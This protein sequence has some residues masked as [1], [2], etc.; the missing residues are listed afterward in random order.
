MMQYNKNILTVGEHEFIYVSEHGRDIERKQISLNDMRVLM[1]IDFKLK[2]TDKQVF[3]QD[4]HKIKTQSFVGSIQIDQDLI[5]EILPKFIKTDKDLDAKSIQQYR[6]TLMNMIMLSG[7]SKFL[8]SNNVALKTQNGELP[9]FETLIFF[10][11]EALSQELRKG[12][13]REYMK[14]S[15]NLTQM[16]GRLVTHEHLRRNI[17]NHAKLYVEFETYSIDNNLMRIF[18]AAIRL[19]LEQN[20]ISQITKQKLSEALYL[21]NDVTDMQLALKDFDSVT[22]HRMNSRFEEL[23]SQCRFLIMKF[24]PFSITADSKTKFWSILFDMDELFED[25]LA[26]LFARSEISFEDQY[27]FHAYRA[28]YGSRSVGGRPDFVFFQEDTISSVADAKW[29]LFDPARSSSTNMGG[30]DWGNFWQLTSYMYLLSK[31]PIPGYFIVPAKSKEVPREVHYP[32]PREY[33]AD[34]A[35]LTIDFTMPIADILETHRFSW[36]DNNRLRLSSFMTP[37]LWISRLVEEFDKIR[38]T[39][40]IISVEN[41]NFYPYMASLGEKSGCKISVIALLVINSDSD[42]YNETSEYIK[43]TYG[44]KRTMDS[45][46][47]TELAT[48]MINTYSIQDKLLEANQEVVELPDLIKESDRDQITW[49]FFDTTIDNLYTNFAEYIYYSRS[50][51]A[52]NIEKIKNS[53]MKKPNMDVKHFSLYGDKIVVFKF[54][55]RSIIAILENIPT[56]II[57]KAVKKSKTFKMTSGAYSSTSKNRKVWGQAIVDIQAIISA[58]IE[59]KQLKI[60]QKEAK[61]AYEKPISENIVSVIEKP[62]VRV[63]DLPEIKKFKEQID[64]L[65]E[66]LYNQSYPVYTSNTTIEWRSEHAEPEA[67]NIRRSLFYE[68]TLLC[69][70]IRKENHISIELY[71]V[72]PDAYST[73]LENDTT[74]TLDGVN[75]TAQFFSQIEWI[76]TNGKILD[77][78]NRALSN[79]KTASYL[80]AIGQKASYS[81]TA[82]IIKLDKE[83]IKYARMYTSAKAL[84][85]FLKIDVSDSKLHILDQEKIIDRFVAEIARD[86]MAIT[87]NDKRM[88]DLIIEYSEKYPS[89]IKRLLLNQ[90]VLER[91]LDKHIDYMSFTPE[92]ATIVS[93]SIK[94]A[95]QKIHLKGYKA[96]EE[97]ILIPVNGGN[98]AFKTVATQ[99]LAAVAYSDLTDFPPKLINKII[100]T[101][102]R[103]TPS[104]LVPFTFLSNSTIPVETAFNYYFA[105][106]FYNNPADQIQAAIHKA[107]VRLKNE[108]TSMSSFV[109]FMIE[110]T[111]N[112]ESTRIEWDSITQEESDAIVDL[113]DL[114]SDNSKLYFIWRTL[115]THTDN[116]LHLEKMFNGTE[117]LTH[118]QKEIIYIAI[119]LAKM[120]RRAT[121]EDLERYKDLLH[122]IAIAEEALKDEYHPSVVSMLAHNYSIRD[123]T[124]E[125]IFNLYRDSEGIMNLLIKFANIRPGDVSN[126]ILEY[127]TKKAN[128]YYYIEANT[129]TM[130]AHGLKK[131]T[132]FNT[133][134]G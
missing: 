133:T 63:E 62:S 12:L 48:Y 33:H 119:I 109:D 117:S 45:F 31:T 131:Q 20:Q 23:F 73:Y 4:G 49:D 21:L 115:A 27:R 126:M 78:L 103:L 40:E 18:K 92:I 80:S 38:V 9:M 87:F 106:V 44:S 111:Q 82:T 65:S 17:F 124:A 2:H 88:V 46:P 52:S 58:V 51:Y 15:D 127:A 120:Y 47:Y 32:S 70:A 97:A 14:K 91:F 42:L 64:F 22:F 36:D 81:P 60:A 113:G 94:K 121:S 107:E 123:C 29:K 100:D 8:S 7:E 125:L 28:P 90:W 89:A 99:I 25:F 128:S 37:K 77:Y 24:Y 86:G 39:E 101:A 57:I 61:I 95:K 118:K 71:D 93:D 67:N 112:F 53:E 74:I 56:P 1:S 130:L 41:D 11:A 10:F 122:K 26:F 132:Q 13:H 5:I 96:V 30:L 134:K 75:V 85:A 55:K 34:I 59:D 108:S 19:L 66:T 114:I 116:V 76:S 69:S 3:K 105:R 83:R 16:K 110:K 102:E 72:D 79:L 98:T 54:E 104:S 43:E 50:I 6:E 35:I 84:Q 129:E 68:N